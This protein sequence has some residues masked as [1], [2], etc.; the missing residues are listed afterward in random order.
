MTTAGRLGCQKGGHQKYFRAPAISGSTATYGD[1]PFVL[2]ICR[3]C[4]S[5]QRSGSLRVGKPPRE[6]RVETKTIRVKRK[7]TEK[8]ASESGM[9]R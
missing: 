7:T 2:A 9:L 1:G 5:S 6:R 8:T 3:C 4:K